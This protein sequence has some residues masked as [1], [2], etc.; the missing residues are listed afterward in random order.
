MACVD[1]LVEEWSD[2]NEPD[3]RPDFGVAQS[4]VRREGKEQRIVLRSRRWANVEKR[5]RLTRTLLVL[6]ER[7]RTS[8]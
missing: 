2:D 5:T 4:Q 7:W 1:R 3:P 6:L 8:R